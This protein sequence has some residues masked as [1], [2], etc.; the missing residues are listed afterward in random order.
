MVKIGGLQNGGVEDIIP[1]QCCH[2]APNEMLP[3]HVREL[4]MMAFNQ[5]DID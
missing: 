5:D 1:A 2:E 3:T 4:Q